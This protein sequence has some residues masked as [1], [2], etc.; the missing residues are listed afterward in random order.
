MTEFLVLLAHRKTGPFGVSQKPIDRELAL[1]WCA[2]CKVELKDFKLL[3]GSYQA[4]LVCEAPRF[5]TM[6]QLVRSAGLAKYRAEILLTFSEKDY[7]RILTSMQPLRP[8]IK[9]KAHP[10]R[11]MAAGAPSTR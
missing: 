6:A 2:S 5:P 8:P 3:F 10:A 1:R 11:A 7:Q 4:M 9:Y